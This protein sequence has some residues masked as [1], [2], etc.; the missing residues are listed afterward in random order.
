[1]VS[2]ELTHVQ[3]TYFIGASMNDA[4]SRNVALTHDR[5]I[6]NLFSV[7]LTEHCSQQVSYQI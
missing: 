1:M 4:E 2:P 3:G 5:S 7:N 6:Q